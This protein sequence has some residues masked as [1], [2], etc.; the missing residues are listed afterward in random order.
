M[1]RQNSSPAA[2][3]WPSDSVYYL[4]LPVCAGRRVLAATSGIEIDLEAIRDPALRLSL[5]EAFAGIAQQL[6]TSG[7]VAGAMPTI[8][9]SIGALIDTIKRGSSGKAV[10]VIRETLEPEQL[11]LPTAA[12][13]FQGA[14]TP[15]DDG[16]RGAGGGEHRH[17]RRD[18][19]GVDGN[20]HRRRWTGKPR[21]T[22]RAHR[23]WRHD[24]S[25]RRGSSAAAAIGGAALDWLIS[26]VLDWANQALGKW[27]VANKDLFIKYRTIRRRR[28]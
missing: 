12:A 19:R 3:P 4:E 25:G 28:G 2:K 27:L 26:K 1:C 9:E 7:A 21:L 6:K 22:G 20:R 23:R 11:T 16:R 17:G 15:W 5:G 8:A 14:G 13:V 24:G 18:E 10:R